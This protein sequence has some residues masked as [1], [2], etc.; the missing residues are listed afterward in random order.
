MQDIYIY[1]YI[2]IYIFIITSYRFILNICAGGAAHFD[3]FLVEFLRNSCGNS[4]RLILSW[5]VHL[6]TVHQFLLTVCIID[7]CSYI[8][9]HTTYNVTYNVAYN[10]HTMLRTI[11]QDVT[12]MLHTRIRLSRTHQ[13][14]VYSQDG[15]S[16]VRPEPSLAANSLGHR[17]HD[18]TG[19]ERQRKRGARITKKRKTDETL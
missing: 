14:R 6:Y 1:I 16:G 3:R 15:V 12:H 7:Q 8:E 9:P 4:P 18:E 2:Y 13:S 5:F 19:R 11:S 17:T 10:V